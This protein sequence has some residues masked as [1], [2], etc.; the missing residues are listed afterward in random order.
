MRQNYDK[1]LA[2]VSF[3][4]TMLAIAGT[5]ALILGILGIYGVISYAVSQRTREIG[6]RLA[7]GAQKATLRW[8]FVRSALLLTCIG[9]A[10]GL[11]TAA[12]LTQFMKSLLFG[13]NPLD[14][15]T[16]T[17]HPARPHHCRGHRQLPSRPPRCL[18]RSRRSP[19][20]RAALRAE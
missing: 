6:I 16:F 12:G 3:T 5:M 7:L 18:C 9:V 8:I 1:S 15:I 14:P 20:S 2:R 17:S 4:L 19:A 10:V 13:I 11:I